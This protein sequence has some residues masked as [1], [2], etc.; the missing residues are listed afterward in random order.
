MSGFEPV[1]LK[2]R[3]QGTVKKRFLSAGILFMVLV[4]MLAAIGTGYALWSKT[5]NIEGTV[6]T[7]T[8]DA[9]FD[10]ASASD[11]GTDPGYD[12]DVAS[13]TVSGVNSQTLTIT[14]DN[15]YPSYTCDVDF[16]VTNTG[17]VPVKVHS[18]DTSGVPS[19]LDVTLTGLPIGTQ[20]D[21]GL[22][23]PGDVHIHVNQTADQ[24]ATYTFSASI[25]LNQWNEP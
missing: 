6:N 13:C 14:I 25:Q 9:D 21:A 2:K 10:S 20:I 4:G 16:T 24:G 19:Q 8:V 11:T 1:R 5:L 17:T 15:G 23:A 7:G 22:E 3:R 18:F 12:K